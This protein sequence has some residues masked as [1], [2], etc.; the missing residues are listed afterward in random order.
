MIL[1]VAGYENCVREN[2]L[3]LWGSRDIAP[4]RWAILAI[5]WEKIAILT[6]F[7]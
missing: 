6:P 2:K 1:K 3:P 7:E 5:F 4:S